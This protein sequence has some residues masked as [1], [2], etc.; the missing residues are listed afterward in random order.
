LKED[1]TWCNPILQLR[2][3]R[4]APVPKKISKKKTGQKGA[5]NN[6]KESQAAS[7]YTNLKIV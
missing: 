6:L 1:L 4:R 2:V 7:I 5:V 3:L